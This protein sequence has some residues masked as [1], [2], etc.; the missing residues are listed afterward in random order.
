MVCSKTSHL[1]HNKLFMSFEMMMM[2][3][4]IMVIII[5]MIIIMLTMIIIVIIKALIKMSIIKGKFFLDPGGY[6][7]ILAANYA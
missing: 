4:M 5:I 2:M 6:I 1:L 7:V 3:M